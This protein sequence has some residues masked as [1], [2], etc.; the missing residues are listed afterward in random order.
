MTKRTDWSD[1]AD[2]KGVSP[3]E[4]ICRAPELPLDKLHGRCLR[5]RL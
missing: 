2:D 1:Q 4:L 5:R 3:V